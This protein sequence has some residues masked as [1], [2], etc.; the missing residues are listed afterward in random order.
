MR[1]DRNNTHA[2]INEGVPPLLAA[3]A[4]Q[5]ETPRPEPRDLLSADMH[6]DGNVFDALIGRRGAHVSYRLWCRISEMELP[7]VEDIFNKIEH[8]VPDDTSL[9]IAMGFLMAHELAARW[10][11]KSYHQALQDC[12]TY[13]YYMMKMGPDMIDMGIELAHNYGV[14]LMKFQRVSIAFVEQS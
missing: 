13:I 3:W 6:E 11:K 12:N 4:M 14:P 8:S 7:K 9:K 10:K 5:C 1:I 2:M